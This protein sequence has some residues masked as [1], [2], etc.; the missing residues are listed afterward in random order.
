M[1]KFLGMI[2]GEYFGMD[3]RKTETKEK[4]EKDL[5]K[6]VEQKKADKQTTVKTTSV[7][8]KKSTEKAPMMN[9]RFTP[10][11]Y[12]YMRQESAMRGLS[13]TGFTNWL[14]DQYKSNPENVHTSGVYKD[15]SNW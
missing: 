8:S 13:V 12:A 4:V 3:E 2:D 5:Q 10:E 14:I 9:I 7:Q 11:N 1:S 6:P 15:E